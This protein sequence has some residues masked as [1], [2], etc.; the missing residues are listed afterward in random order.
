[1]VGEEMKK[2]WVIDEQDLGCD[3]AYLSNDRVVRCKNCKYR[4]EDDCCEMLEFILTR[5]DDYCSW[6]AIK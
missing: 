6:G 4:D 1:M 3:G 2:E 5:D